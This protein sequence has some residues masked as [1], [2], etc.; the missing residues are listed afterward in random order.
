MKEY[1]EVE[2]LLAMYKS[3]MMPSLQFYY[4][5]PMNLVR[6]FRQWL[7]DAKG[8]RY[9]DFFGGILTV[10]SGHSLPEINQEIISQINNLQHTS[11]V[12]LIQ[13]MVELAQKLSAITP[14]ALK[15][16]F[17]VNSGTE[18][19]EGAL[20]LAGIYTGNSHVV[21]IT[22]S[23][24][25]RSMVAQ[26]I[27]GQAPWRSGGASLP[28]ISFT[29][30]AYCYRCAFD[31]EYPGCDLHCA[32]HLEE[33]IQTTTPGRIAALIAEPIQGVGGFITPPKEYFSI[34]ER[35]TREYGGLFICDEVQ[36][37]LG[38]TGQTLFGIE[39]WGVEPDIMTLSKGVANGS[40][41]GV[42]I[43]REEVADSYTGPSICTFGG[44]HISSVAA[45][46]NIAFILQENLMENSRKLG[47]HL[48]TGLQ[49][50]KT[51]SSLIGDVRGK[52]LMVGVELVQDKKTRAPA[53][54]ETAQV[55][56]VA[57]DKGLLVGRGGLYANVLR[58]A[59]P[60]TIEAGDVQ[61]ALTILE[62]AF[63][64]VEGR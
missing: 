7:F 43:A 53:P 33:V 3:Y 11:T 26:G 51:R 31:K 35:I 59:P 10:M 38:R 47:E 34:L 18:A 13:P 49:D 23:Y 28:G 54:K 6:G 9:L 37:A 29:P 12:Y 42:Y 15:K 1:L 30:S 62:E 45:L 50:L 27:T 63:A 44:N 60:L 58:L 21:A 55:M 24:H 8:K 40:P 5:E 14:G 61:S 17:F 56:E 25:G 36:T 22:H 2:E 32:Y 64:S 39:D 19:N 41:M 20:M 4:E 48:M 52:G 16:S 46:A 57:K